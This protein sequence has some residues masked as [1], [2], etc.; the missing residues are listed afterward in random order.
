VHDELH[1]VRADGAVEAFAQAPPQVHVLNLGL[2]VDDHGD[3][4]VAELVPLHVLHPVAP[5]VAARSKIHKPPGTPVMSPD[6]PCGAPM[7]RADAQDRRAEQSGS[8]RPALLA[9]IDDP[10]TISIQSPHQEESCETQYGFPACAGFMATLAIATGACSGEF[11]VPAAN[12]HSRYHTLARLLTAVSAHEATQ[13]R[14]ILALLFVLKNSDG[15]RLQNE[16]FPDT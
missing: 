11:G 8:C 13:C 4:I 10:I 14:Q 1:L 5:R 12:D 6:I 2:A 9:K 7:R 3:V 15:L 16:H